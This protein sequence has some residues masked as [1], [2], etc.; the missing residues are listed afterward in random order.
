MPSSIEPRRIGSLGR[1][2]TGKTPPTKDP[3]NFGG[4]YPFI[5]IPDLD[6]RVYIDKTIRTLSEK[7]ADI[8]SSS[9]LPPDAVMMS[10]IATIGRCGITTQTSFTN[11][12]INSVIC[13][14]EVFPRY[15]YYCF[16]QLEH[17]LEAAGGGGSVYTNVSKSR[18]SD[19]EVP[20]PAMPV[21]KAIAQFLGAIDDRSSIDRMLSLT[22]QDIAQTLFKSWFIDF[23]PV[24]AKMGE[25]EYPM[26]KAVWDAFPDG[27]EETS[28][29]LTPRGWMVSR[30][31]QLAAIE[32]GRQ[33]PTEERG[34]VG[35]YPVYGANGVMGFS[36]RATHPRFVIAFG[37]VG[38]YCGS[39]HWTYGGA[40]INNNASAVV[41]FQ[42]SEY[43]LQAMLNVD[44]AS[45]RK[46][47]A[48]PFIPNGT[49]AEVPVLTPDNRVLDA[50]CAQIH[51][52]REAQDSLNREARSLGLLRDA[53]LPPLLAG[54]I[55]V[56]HLNRANTT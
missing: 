3:D 12:Q 13:G 26:P 21:Q 50:F 40:W 17:Q 54:Q 51:S 46:G 4:Q 37:R 52:L 14:N 2:V 27:L 23:D 39:I 35:P 31:G 45:L 20:V 43:V 22:I 33:L 32:G 38:A 44:F 34:P 11:Q 24:R 47:S 41:P 25:I 29:G 9:K 30:L 56:G 7:G 8:L 10:C 55:E 48:Q 49:L 19:I 28:M 6:G 15:L 18:F 53:V 36:E 16:T 1:V 5:T 42:H